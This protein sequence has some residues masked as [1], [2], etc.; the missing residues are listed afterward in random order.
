MLV[1]SPNFEEE[2]SS[3]RVTRL[4]KRLR[5]LEDISEQPATADHARELALKLG[6]LDAN[7]EAYH[8]D[9][10]DLIEEEEDDALDK[11]Q[12]VLD[13]HDDQI[14]DMNIRLKRLFSVDTLSLNDPDPVKLSSR[15]L[16]H[17]E[18][19]ILVIR[20]AITALP[21]DHGDV[22]LIEQYEF[23]LSDHKTELSKIHAIL[24]SV[25]D[26]SEVGDQLSLH[27]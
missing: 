14:A 5:E 27:S 18:R 25:D 26:E 3:A 1:N 22:S 23:Q 21:T 24:L 16:N 13:E 15:K 17:L 12:E 2:E 20:D 10:I 7:F 6:N 8:F 19:G 4:E 9:L 11:E